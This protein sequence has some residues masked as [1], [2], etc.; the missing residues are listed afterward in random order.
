MFKKAACLLILFVSIAHAGSSF[1]KGRFFRLDQSYEVSGSVFV[2]DRFYIVMD[3][4]HAIYQLKTKNG[5]SVPTMHIDLTKLNGY[6]EYVALNKINLEGI[7]HCPDAFYVVNE[8]SNDILKVTSKEV[9]VLSIDKSHLG[10]N[11][12]SKN[13]LEGIAIDCSRNI[14]FV[15]SQSFPQ[16]VVLYQ[17][18]NS[19]YIAT[20]DL[21]EGVSDK[22][23]NV[24]DLSFDGK[25]LY[26]L[27]KN[28]SSVL[29]IHVY[30]DVKPILDRVDYS[31]F[32]YLFESYDEKGNVVNKDFAEGLVVR[33]NNYF[34]FY[35]QGKAGPVSQKG[36]DLGLDLDSRGVVLQLSR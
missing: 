10:F 17:L 19:K 27:Q 16:K 29:A 3:N 1:E 24:S 33:G 9:K 20:F 30:G 11:A 15:A 36:N 2:K 7:A 23:N 12:A 28:R 32:A 13:G 4:L 6:A 31:K 8:S 22:K 34:L 25:T 18:T 21:S 35:D 26:V 5:Q 14:L